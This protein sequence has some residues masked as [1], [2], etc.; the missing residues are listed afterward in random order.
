MPFFVNGC[1]GNC[2]FENLLTKAV[3]KITWW[4]HQMETFS[5]LLAICAGNSPG[6]GHAELCC[7][8]WSAWING[9]VKNREACDL[10][11]HHAHYDVTVMFR[12]KDITV[13]AYLCGKLAST[14]SS[15]N[16]SMKCLVTP[17][18]KHHDNVM[19]R[20]YFPLYKPFCGVMGEALLFS[21]C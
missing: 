10:R 17:C 2:H 8:L 12:H 4:R 7:F 16:K 3:T 19:L 15:R 9:W 14:I 20:Q 1:A 11:R 6:T 18:W 13:S 5:A 21:V